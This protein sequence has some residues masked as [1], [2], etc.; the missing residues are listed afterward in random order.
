MLKQ[1]YCVYN[2]FHQ[3]F[4]LY[5]F[6]NQKL[7]RLDVADEAIIDKYA[8]KELAFPV[9]VKEISKIKGKGL[10]A[11][12]PIKKAELVATYSGNVMTLSQVAKYGDPTTNQYTFELTYGPDVT[13][14]FAVYPKDYASAGYFMN[15]S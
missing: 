9:A 15:H 14:N 6:Y 8:R 5:P 3:Y 2:V 11:R 12:R 1:Q 13:S 10:V 7:K 4:E